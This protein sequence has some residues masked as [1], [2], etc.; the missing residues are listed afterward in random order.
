MLY[1]ISKCCTPIPGEPIVGAVTRS[2]GVSVHRIDCPTLNDIPPER[3]MEISWS[4]VD[5]NKVYV[6]PIK[7][8]TEDK[9]G[10]MQLVLAKVTD[11]KTNIAFASGFSKQNKRGIIE[12][13]L[14]VRDIESLTKIMN[15]IQS[16]PEVVSVKRTHAS[17]NMRRGR[18]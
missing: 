15:S 12:L 13:G 16:L 1:H 4:S 10:V 17:Q 7:I 3:L 14:E 18:H 6:V 11:S 9:V 2:R 8:E 5:S